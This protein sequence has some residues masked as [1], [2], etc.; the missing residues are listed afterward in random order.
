MR[1]SFLCRGSLP[2]LCCS[3]AGSIRKKM[4]FFTPPRSRAGSI[5][6][7]LCGAADEYSWVRGATDR[8]SSASPL[9]R[10]TSIGFTRGILWLLVLNLEHLVFRGITV[11]TATECDLCFFSAVWLRKRNTNRDQPPS[12]V[13]I[14]FLVGAQHCLP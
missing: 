14:L 13:D 3:M 5:C 7:A 12:A 9:T 2:P 8:R 4:W 1:A 11:S 10:T 6:A